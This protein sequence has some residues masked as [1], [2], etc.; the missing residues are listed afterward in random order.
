MNIET[1]IWLRDIIEKIERKH[2]LTTEEVEQVFAN[3]PHFRFLEKGKVEGENLCSAMGQTDEGRYVI[4]Y[5][6]RKPQH[7]ALVISARE[8]DDNERGNYG[9]K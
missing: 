8:M 6:I 5:F 1:I 9:K 3:R 4:V 2:H 7:E